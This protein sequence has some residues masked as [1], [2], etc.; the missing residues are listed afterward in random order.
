MGRDL[1][2]AEELRAVVRWMDNTNEGVLDPYTP[3]QLIQLYEMFV[4]SGWDFTLDQWTE[5]QR[6]EALGGKPPSWNDEE[7]PV[8]ADTAPIATA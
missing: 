2:G 8:Y 3:A 5:R 6:I 4:A 7:Q 1:T